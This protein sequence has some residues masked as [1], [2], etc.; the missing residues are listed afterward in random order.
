M[1]RCSHEI[2]NDCWSILENVLGE[3]ARVPQS[4]LLPTGAAPEGFDVIH[5]DGR[6]RIRCLL[7]ALASAWHAQEAGV[8]NAALG[9]FRAKILLQETIY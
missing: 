7:E 3:Y 5:M 8:R 1:D 2:S 9:Q 6:F 4:Y